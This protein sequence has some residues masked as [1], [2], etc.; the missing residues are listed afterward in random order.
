[1][2]KCISTPPIHRHLNPITLYG[3]ASFLSLPEQTY[4]HTFLLNPIITLISFFVK[5][6]KRKKVA[7]TLTV[8]TASSATPLKR[9]SFFLG[10]VALT[11]IATARIRVATT[12][13]KARQSKEKSRTSLSF[14]IIRGFVAVSSGVVPLLSHFYY[15]FKGY[16]LGFVRK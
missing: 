12:P 11:L 13:Q 1:M 2:L 3:N 6:P 9:K 8:A 7:L 16:L 4:P 14:P 15:S 10:I 5:P